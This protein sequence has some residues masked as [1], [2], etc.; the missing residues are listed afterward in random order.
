MIPPL[1]KKNRNT[2]SNIL[3]KPY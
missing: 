3:L 1:Y 2:M